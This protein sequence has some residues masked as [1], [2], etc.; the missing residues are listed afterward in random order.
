AKRIAL[1][2]ILAA[3]F[4]LVFA[5]EYPAMR[6]RG[7]GHF[8]GGPVFG[9]WLRLKPIPFFK[10]GEYVFRFR[11]M[12]REEM[13]LQLFAEGMGG[14]NRPELT[15]LNTQ[16]E[17]ILVDQKGGVV[18]RAS[19]VIPK[20]VDPCCQDCKE[21][22]EDCQPLTDEQIEARRQKEWVLMSGGDEAAYW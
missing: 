8:S 21:H 17:A 14:N 1:F 20:E 6:F 13:S 18:C 5:D 19:G 16:L 10:P 22:P 3:P 9:Y 12:P 2:A 15:N 11:G 7:D 4:L